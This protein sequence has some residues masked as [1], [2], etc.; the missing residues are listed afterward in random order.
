M[1]CVNPI[2]AGSFGAD[3]AITH[4]DDV[5][6][7]IVGS[8]DEQTGIDTCI[9]MYVL[10]LGLRETDVAARRQLVNLKH[11][12]GSPWVV[13]QEWAVECMRQMQQ[14]SCAAFVIWDD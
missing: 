8:E 3:V 11:T 5:T 4:T 2:V 12:P 9:D 14:L 10:W 13:R 6:H 1:K 7:I